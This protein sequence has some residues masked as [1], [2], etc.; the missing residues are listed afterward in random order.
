MKRLVLMLC[1]VSCFGFGTLGAADCHLDLRPPAS[2]MKLASSGGAGEQGVLRRTDLAAGSSRVADLSV[3]DRLAIDLFEDVSTVVALTERLES[4]VGGTAFLARVEEGDGLLTACVV[5]GPDGLQLTVQDLRH[6]RVYTVVSSAAGTTVREFDPSAGRIEP[7]APILDDIEG[8][9]EFAAAQARQTAAVADQSSTLVDVLVAYDAGAAEWTRTNGGSLEGFA[10]T[11][12]AKMNLAMANNGF[13]SEFRFRLVGTLE[14]AARSTDL[15]EALDLVRGS[16]SGW[17]AI[18]QQRR[19]LGADIVSVLIDTGSA[20]GVVGLGSA[21]NSP[22]MMTYVHGQVAANVCA[23]RSVAQSHTM[24]HEV[25][26]NM[27]A[28]HATAVNPDQISPGPQLYDYSAGYYFTANGTAYHTIMAYNFDGFGHYY[29]QAPLF[30]SPNR[31]WEGAVA[32]DALHDNE[33]TIRNTYVAVS[34]WQPQKIPL[35]YDVLFDPVSETR[36]EESVIVN[37]LPGKA[38]LEI[39]YTTDGSEPTLTSPVYAEPL[40]ITDT[41]TIKAATVMDGRLGPVFSARYVKIGLALALGDPSRI[42][43]TGEEYPW[44]CQEKYTYDGMAAQSCPAFVAD[45]G[46]QQTSWL[47]TTVEGPLE[48]SF[49]YQKR[50]V[51]AAF[52]VSCDGETLWIDNPRGYVD[53]VDANGDWEQAFVTLPEGRHAVRFAFEKGWGVVSGFNG[54]YLDDVTFG[55][56]PMP[57]TVTP[58]LEL[59]D[60]LPLTVTLANP[61]GKGTVYYTMDGSDPTISTTRQTVAGPIE[62][63]DKRTVLTAVVQNELGV[64]GV[65]LQKRFPLYSDFVNGCLGSSEEIFWTMSGE[66]GWQAADLAGAPAFRTGG[67]MEGPYVSTLTARVRGKGT[68]SFSYKACICSDSNGASYRLNEAAPVNIGFTWTNYK[69]NTVTIE[70]DGELSVTWTYRVDDPSCDYTDRYVSGGQSL[71][72]G[73]WL[74]DVRWTPQ[75]DA[76]STTS[77]PV[78]YAWI[79]ERFPTADRAD[80]ETLMAED[81]DGDGYANWIEYLCGTDPHQATLDGV[82][83]CAIAVNAGESEITHNLVVPGAAQALG[84]RA[85]TYG[86]ADLKS[87]QVVTDK[88]KGAYRFFKVKVEQPGLL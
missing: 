27:G 43:T 73:L 48:L 1:S 38:G 19:A 58:D 76:T 70:V 72:S 15:Y 4:P 29:Q 65:P 66:A 35:S 50:M 13:S 36:F 88:T 56:Y 25:G 23:V 8:P 85:T 10:Q 32:G 42:W 37:L 3:G 41:T 24:T 84:W 6:D 30:S 64:Y 26:H 61:N 44:V 5:Q 11:A 81:S 47:E 83:H 49:R 75:Q 31:T 54:I 74:T 2:R 71:W 62:I 12:V 45:A 82:P 18:N 21:P 86:S 59:Y 14:V 55:K 68:F 79:A 17:E 20:H 22:D 39:R 53:T 67:L 80:Y 51:S 40:T 60:R 9:V 46:S 63:T 34:Q 16:K 52:R 78:P 77:V 33:R 28:G 7:A 57:P 69:Q 87:W